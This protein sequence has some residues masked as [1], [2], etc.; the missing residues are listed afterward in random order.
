LIET[1]ERNDDRFRIVAILPAHADFGKYDNDTQIERLREADGE[2]GRFH[3]YSLYSSGPTAGRFGFGFVPI[4]VHAKVAIVDD[5]WFMI[6]FANLNRRGLA[7]DSEMNAQSVDAAGAR[8]LRLRLWPEHLRVEEDEI[9]D[10][11]PLIDHGQ[12]FVPASREV[13]KRVRAK[14]GV[15]PALIHPYQTGRMPGLWFLQHLE[16]L[17]EGL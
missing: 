16:S 7:P 11:D 1:L 12:R 13:A 9:A 8:A 2:R 10:L 15:L 17:V 5:A 3:A 6:G 14:R 4:Y